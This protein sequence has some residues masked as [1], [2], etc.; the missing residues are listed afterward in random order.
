MRDHRSQ[1]TG[2]LI[3]ASIFYYSFGEV[4]VQPVPT[5]LA[6]D[7]AHVL[8]R[9][10]L[11]L[12]RRLSPPVGPSQLS[13]QPPAN[14]GAF[15]PRPPLPDSPRLEVPCLDFQET[16]QTRARPTASLAVLFPVSRQTPSL[17][18]FEFSLWL[19][20]LLLLLRLLLQK[21]CVSSVNVLLIIG[22]L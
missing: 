12:D 3:K 21:Y 9:V 17:G 20:L 19:L 18:C 5:P 2:G 7:S 10:I 14:C 6:R 13:A 1:R 16:F 15:L 8:V 22:C 11:H 4:F